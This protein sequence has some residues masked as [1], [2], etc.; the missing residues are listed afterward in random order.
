MAVDP[1]DRPTTPRSELGA[2][3]DPKRP[4]TSVAIDDESPAWLTKALEAM[5]LIRVVEEAIGTLV[6]QGFAKAPCHLGIGQEAVAVGVAAHLRATDRIFG[7][8]RSHSHYLAVGGDVYALIAEVLGKA[9]GASRGMGGSMH[10]YAKQIGFYGSVPIVGATIPIAVGAGLAAKLSGAS[11]VAVAFFGDGAA[12]EGVFHESMN[13]A[14][15]QQLPVLFVCE[16]N[17]YSSHLDISLRQPADCIARYADAH[18]VPA[19]IVDGNDVVAVKRAA[20]ELVAAARAGKGPGFLEA[21]TYRHRGHVGPKDDIDV[22]V[23]RSMTELTAWKRLDPIARLCAAL[24]SNGLVTA[25]RIEAQTARLRRVA[26]DA[27]VRARAAPYPAT[28]ALLDM[29]YAPERGNER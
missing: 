4:V 19:R 28:S 5:T 10:L 2:L 29:V 26:A 14:A 21:V 16:N 11:D 24:L 7:G 3:S 20:G 18:R 23:R 12:E 9:D 27:C 1:D 6:E 13:L 8:H 22:G 17:L 15:V 25:A